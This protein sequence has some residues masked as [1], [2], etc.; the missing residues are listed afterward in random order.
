M[1]SISGTNNMYGQGGATLRP[2]PCPVS[3][4]GDEASPWFYVPSRK[5]QPRLRL[6]CFPYAGGRPGI[7]RSW[8]DRLPHSV[9]LCAI[10]LPGRSVRDHEVPQSD[11]FSLAGELADAIG[12]RSDARFAFFGH[13]MG[14]LLAYE[15]ARELRARG[16]A[17]PVHMFLSA[18]GA[19]HC[20]APRTTPVDAM[21]NDEL[22]EHLTALGGTPQEI[23]NDP[24]V[25]SIMMP[26]IRADFR[27]LDRWKYRP[28]KPLRIP[29]SAL[30][31]RDD[32]TVDVASVREWRQH[33]E[34]EFCF[35]VL[36][37]AHFFLHSEEPMLL[38][39]IVRTLSADAWI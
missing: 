24:R 25:M 11:I 19:V 34:S 33:T 2:L 35:Y 10:T 5:A 36:D 15:V 23:L 14:A 16:Y 6:F 21:S 27:A 20:V 8:S 28:Q 3:G 29:I 30:A 32:A 39:I 31:G 13:S 4:G 17:L 37:G 26:M 9:E 7:F 12:Q 38:D 22:I 18:R 1:T